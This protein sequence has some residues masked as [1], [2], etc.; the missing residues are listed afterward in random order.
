MNNP[1]NI[2]ALEAQLENEHEERTML[3]REK[4]ELERRITDLQDR[5]ITHVDEDYVHKLKKELKK[6][7]VL[8]RDTQTMLE[9]AQSEGS[10][11]VLV[12]QLKTQ[13]TFGSFWSEVLVGM[14]FLLKVLL[15]YYL[16]E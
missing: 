11:K 9:K 13:V 7:K 6:T 2:T 1:Y 10:H 12:R 4:H 3:V 8:L 14:L 16:L 15:C 5:T